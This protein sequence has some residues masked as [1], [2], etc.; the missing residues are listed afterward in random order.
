MDL[1]RLGAMFT[2]ATKW[3]GYCMAIGL[4]RLE[5]PKL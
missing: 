1:R 5:I 4:A 3:L 2:G